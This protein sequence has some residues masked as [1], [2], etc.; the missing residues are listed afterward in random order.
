MCTCWN[1][2]DGPW[3]GSCWWSNNNKANGASSTVGL[4]DDSGLESL[5][6]RFFVIFVSI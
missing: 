6:F 3:L 5:V 1:A 2:L 4:N